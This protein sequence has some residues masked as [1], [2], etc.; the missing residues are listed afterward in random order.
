MLYFKDVPVVIE[1]GV[2]ALEVA[3]VSVKNLVERL[4][5]VPFERVVPSSA[6]A[7]KL[8]FV[9]S[10]A[11]PHVFSMRADLDNSPFLLVYSAQGKLSAVYTR[12]KPAG[13]WV[14]NEAAPEQVGDVVT[15]FSV[16]F[17]FNSAAQRSQFVDT[18]DTLIA[19][20]QNENKIAKTQVINLLDALLESDTGP[21]LLPV[22]VA[23]KAAS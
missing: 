21:V 1:P 9:V 11:N 17:S 12:D 19:S 7:S 10:S 16:R 18:L 6:T 14:R 2:A 3:I 8:P 23:K 22:A 13:N 15:Q 4:F 5:F 20:Y